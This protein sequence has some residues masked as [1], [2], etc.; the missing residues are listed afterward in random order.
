[1]PTSRGSGPSSAAGCSITK[2][3]EALVGKNAA[4]E[5]VVQ[6]K[7]P[8]TPAKVQQFR[9]NYQR[10]VAAGILKSGGPIGQS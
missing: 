8:I 9:N 6:V 4:G 1:M 10:A 2:S 5:I 3:S 7:G